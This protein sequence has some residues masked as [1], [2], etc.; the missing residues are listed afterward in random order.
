MEEIGEQ[1]R[2]VVAVARSASLLRRSLVFFLVR[3]IASHG[4]SFHGSGLIMGWLLIG[5]LRIGWLNAR[6][7]IPIL[8]VAI[9]KSREMTLVSESIHMLCC[10]KDVWECRQATKFNLLSDVWFETTNEAVY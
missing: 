6:A 4:I 10:G 3:L 5:L 8:G 9:A 1:H 7:V 2:P